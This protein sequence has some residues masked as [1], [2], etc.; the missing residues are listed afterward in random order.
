MNKTNLGQR[1]IRASSRQAKLS[2]DKSVASKK[3]LDACC[4]GRMM[5]FNKTHPDALYIDKRSFP[6]ETM[7]NNQ[8]FSV[9]PDIVMDFRSMELP[10]ESFS[11]V[12][13]DPPH[14]IRNSEA[15]YISR[16]YGVLSKETWRDDIKQGFAECWRVLKP[17]GVL[18]FKWSESNI[19]VSE[20]LKLAPAQ[21]LFGHKTTQHTNTIWLTFMKLTEAAEKGKQDV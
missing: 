7:T 18:I 14:I 17:D 16:K 20:V 11:L 19:K 3:I 5:W 1:E 12:V 4:G 21:P 15:G 8:T 13:F 6:P 2:P 10:D 9:L